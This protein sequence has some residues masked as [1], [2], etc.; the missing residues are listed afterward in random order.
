MI[1]RI[2][3]YFNFNDL[4]IV[5]VYFLMKKGRVVYIGKTTNGLRRLFSHNLMGLFDKIRIIECNKNKVDFYEKRWIIK[6]RPKYNR[7]HLFIKIGHWSTGF[8]YH[9]INK[10][11]A[12]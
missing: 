3:K 4:R 6:F 7:R 5:G 1:L 2:P 10:K 11:E 8:K 9:P 12:A